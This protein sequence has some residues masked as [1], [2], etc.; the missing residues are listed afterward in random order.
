MKERNADYWINTLHLAPHPEGGYFREVFRSMEKI[1]REGLPQRFS[2]ERNFLTSIYY[3]LRKGERSS[4][5][6]LKSDELWYFHDGAP[7]SVYA[8]SEDGVSRHVLGLDAASGQLP[9][10][11]IPAGCWFGA[12]IEGEGGYSLVGCAVAPGF[13]FADFELASRD[14]MLARYPHHRSLVEK[15]TR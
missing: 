12:V 3:L 6:R 14:A 4:L 5:H 8:L 1:A 15:L 2:G 9:Q 13:D 11:V 10:A 7:L